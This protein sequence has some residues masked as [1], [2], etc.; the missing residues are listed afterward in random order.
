ML[1]FCAILSLLWPALFN[2][3]SIFFYDSIGYLRGGMQA[4][5]VF[6]GLET[7]WT[8]AMLG[9]AGTSSG[10]TPETASIGN[11]TDGY[12]ST[13][14]SVYYG[15]MLFLS[16]YAGGL[17]LSILIQ[18][19]LVTGSVLMALQL[20]SGYCPYGFPLVLIGLGLF[21][22]LSFFI[23]YL[24][25]DAFAGV[26]VLSV[27]ALLVYYER[28]PNWM[29]L[30]WIALLVLSMAFHLSHIAVAMLLAIPGIFAVHILGKKSRWKLSGVFTGV[31]FVGIMSQIA[32]YSTVEFVYGHK[33][34]Q[35]PFLMSRVI[36]DGPGYRY[37]LATCPS[38]GFKICS[39]LQNLPAGND[40][41]LWSK[42]P[43]AGIYGTASPGVRRE[44]EHEQL[45]FVI[46]VIRFDFAGQML[47]S[48]RGFWKQ[49]S[50]F[51]IGEFV[52][53]DS[54]RLM[55]LENVPPNVGVEFENSRL[56]RD[57]FP[58]SKV[59][60]AFTACFLLSALVLLWW[61]RSVALGYRNLDAAG[62]L[63]S[64]FFVFV[65][66]GFILN[67]MVTGMLS[68]PHDRYQ[69]RIVWLIPLLAA[70]VFLNRSKRVAGVDAA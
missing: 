32:L 33:P 50:L 35:P 44:L 42:D 31:M 17:W 36:A 12:I 4:S 67:A 52:Y 41:F 37:L 66:S 61:G 11:Y 57:E 56:Y 63:Q 62:K 69:S 23:N 25:P 51:G 20:T 45:A 59:N 3:Q 21:T 2:G 18:G 47:A 68:T 65:V 13:A 28:M 15:L 5:R 58:L 39:F 24:M 53:T 34:S 70:I 22:P 55:V 27:S 19:L 9:N 14:R 30:G 38:N 1:Y 48:V 54:L 29:R 49:L 6:F 43:K 8:E 46:E 64:T 16:E 40:E 10:N 7:A 60:V 26:A